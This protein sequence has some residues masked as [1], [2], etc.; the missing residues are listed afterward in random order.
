MTPRQKRFLGVIDRVGEN[1]VVG[2]V[3]QR[4]IVSS[5]T[6]GQAREFLPDGVLSAL[7]AR[8]IYTAYVG[9]ASAAAV[10]DVAA[11]EG[12]TRSVAKVVALRVAG[13][14]VAQLLVLT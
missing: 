7:T 8:P 3:S 4:G 5:I 11:W 12:E 14:T 13:E 6:P 10:D 2:G 1:L 9:F